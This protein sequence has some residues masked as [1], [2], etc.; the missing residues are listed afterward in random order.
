MG[1]H[2]RSLERA[3]LTCAYCPAE[4]EI[5]FNTLIAARDAAVAADLTAA[6]QDSC[7][8]YTH[9]VKPET[10]CGLIRTSAFRRRQSKTDRL[11][12]G[13]ERSFTA[14]GT[15]ITNGSEADQT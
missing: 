12:C 9:R 8:Q 11:K 5:Q 14:R 13:A 4:P 3:P 15:K 1:T 10:W 7:G 6:P 2:Q